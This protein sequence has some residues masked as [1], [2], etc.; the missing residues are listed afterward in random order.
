M[1]E[2]IELATQNAALLEHPNT[3]L[4]R[5]LFSMVYILLT[6]L[7]TGPA[8]KKNGLAR[9]LIGSCEEAS[10]HDG[11]GPSCQG[12]GDIPGILDTAVGN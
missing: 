6:N 3:S 12:L 7:R 4:S 8:L 1:I 2:I 10:D 9:A 5:S 11:I